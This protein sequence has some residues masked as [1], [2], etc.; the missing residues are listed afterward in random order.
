MFKNFLG[1]MPSDPL[2]TDMLRMPCSYYFQ[3]FHFFLKKNHPTKNPSYGHGLETSVQD[4]SVINYCMI[5]II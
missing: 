5:T 2:E 1:G 4:S 3:F